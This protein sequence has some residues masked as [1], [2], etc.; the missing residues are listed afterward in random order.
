[1]LVLSGLGCGYRF[2][3]RGS[4]LPEG[5]KA[6]CA[7][8]FSNETPEP[9]LEVLFTDAFR[10]ELV[11]SGTLASGT[12][13]ARVEGAVLGLG[14]APTITSPTTGQL[15]SY[16]AG[17]TVRLRLVKDGRLLRETVVSGSEDFLPP[18]SGD[19]L[20]TEANRQA[21][22]H[23]LAETMMREGFERLA[24]GG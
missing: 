14:S 19:I 11:R 4:E 21:A 18:P 24:S 13:E 12:C 1:M 16:R 10:R 8:V 5:V 2:V 15:V 22:L 17:A 9:T 3:P 20:E 7:P 23:R 6:L